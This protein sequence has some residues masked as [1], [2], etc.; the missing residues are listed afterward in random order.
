[1]ARKPSARVVL[2]RAALNRVELAIADGFSAVG[3]AVLDTTEPPDATPFGEG[4]VTRGGFLVYAAGKKVDGFGQDGRQPAKP[5]AVRV[6]G[7]S[8]LQL[9]VGFGFPGRFQELGTIRQP[10][11]P[12]LTPAAG[13]VLPLAAQ[14][15][16]PV[17]RTALRRIA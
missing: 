17:V 14:I 8:W 10:A 6:Q 5:R 9:I 2:N 16:S 4:L 12:F 1:M 3:H 15:M 13:R 7:E 11:R